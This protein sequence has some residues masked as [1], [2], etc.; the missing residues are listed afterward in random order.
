M[1]QLKWIITVVMLSL[2]GSLTACSDMP[3]EKSTGQYVDDAVISTK[4]RADLIADPDLKNSFDIKVDTY[5]GVV[6]L[7]GFV[8]SKDKMDK[9][10]QIAQ[11]VEGVKAVKNDMQLK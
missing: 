5:K 8:G 7:S 4:V 3:T 11:H 2:V 10:I 9:A 1:K 6:Q